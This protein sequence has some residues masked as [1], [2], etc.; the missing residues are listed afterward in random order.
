MLT[1][2]LSFLGGSA[3]RMIFGEVSSYFQKKQDKEAELELMRLQGELDASHHM[4]DLERMRLQSELGVKEIQIKGDVDIEKIDASAFV[5]AMKSVNQPTGIQWVDAWNGIIRPLAAT[6]AL[7]L[8]VFAL[9]EAGFRMG[10]WDRELV[11]VIIGFWFANR[12][13]SKNGK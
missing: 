7:L 12:V 1:G 13:M 8:W 4:Q 10:D 6:M 3:F 9:N 11:A 2:L 5:E